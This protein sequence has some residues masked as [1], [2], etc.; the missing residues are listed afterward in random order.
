MANRALRNCL[1]PSSPFQKR[2]Q[3]ALRRMRS[4]CQLKTWSQRWTLMTTE[5]SA[6]TN[7]YPTFRSVQALQLHSLNLWTTPALLQTSAPSS[8]RRP[9][10]RKKSLSLRPSWKELAKKRKQRFPK[11]SQSSRGK[12]SLWVRRLRKPMQMQRPTRLPSVLGQTQDRPRKT[13]GIR[14][15]CHKFI[16]YSLNVHP[17]LLTLEQPVL[18]AGQYFLSH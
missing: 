15:E 9:R 3:R 2:S 1:V 17:N 18:N 16:K 10:E 11:R 8:S 7:G 13:E 12:W 6:L 14:R 5:C 4:I